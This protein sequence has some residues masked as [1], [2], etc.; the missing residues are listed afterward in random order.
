MITPSKTSSNR[1]VVKCL[2]KHLLCV[3]RKL[4]YTL[5]RLMQTIELCLL[6]YIKLHICGNADVLVEDLHI[7]PLC[8]Y[9][10]H[11]HPVLLSS[12]SVPVVICYSAHII[13]TCLSFVFTVYDG[14]I[15]YI[16]SRKRPFN[17]MYTSV[18]VK[19]ESKISH[20]LSVIFDPFHV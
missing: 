19:H 10:H 14:S 15:C 13:T 8:S 1:Q 17:C 2:R 12:I 4:T 20:L 5:Q 6:C 3:D 9:H 11:V 18:R 16:C 7:F